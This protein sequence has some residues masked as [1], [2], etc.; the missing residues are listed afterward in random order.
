MILT[1]YYFLLKLSSYMVVFIPSAFKRWMMTQA[2]AVFGAKDHQKT[3]N[4]P[5]S[6]AL[7][8]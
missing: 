7:D 5:C 4:Q 1:K 6:E 8:F 2:T 3:A